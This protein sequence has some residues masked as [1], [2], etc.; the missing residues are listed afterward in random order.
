MTIQAYDAFGTNVGYCVKGGG[1]ENGNRK[2][3]LTVAHDLAGFGS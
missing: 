2:F 3:S 1:R